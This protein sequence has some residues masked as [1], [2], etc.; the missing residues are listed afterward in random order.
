MSRRMQFRGWIGALL[1]ALA[2]AGGAC[3]AERTWVGAA[4]GDWFQAANWDGGVRPADGDSVA[5]SNG[6]WI[7]I[8]NDTPLLD[9]FAITNATLVFTNWDTT[10][11]A[12]SVLV[13]NSG[14]LTMP[15][16]FA[17]ASNRIH[18]ACSNLTVEP[19]G[20]I[21]ARGLGY[22]A[23]FGPGAGAADRG[24]G[25]G[26][27]GR[28][29]VGDTDATGGGTYDSAG[30]PVA[31][32][33]GGCSSSKGGSGGG[34]VRIDASGTI[35]I[36]GTITAD[37][38]SSTVNYGGGGSGGSVLII[39]D[40]FA[41]GTGGLVSASGGAGTSPG[42]GGGGGRLAIL[43]SHATPWPGV[44]LWTSPGSGYNAAF[45]FRAEA[46]TLHLADL[47]A[48]APVMDANRFR[49][50]NLTIEGVATCV[51][52]SL[53][54][55]NCSFRLAQPG[56][57]LI[58][59]NALVVATNAR[60]GTDNLFCDR[61]TITNGGV[62]EIVSA[63]TNGVEPD[64]GALIAVT[65]GVLI[66]PAS[67]LYLFAD[68]MTGGAP[69]LRADSV[70]VASGGAI[71][72]D[73]GGFETARGPGAG[74]TGERCAGGGYGGAGGRGQYAASG[75]SSYGAVSEPLSAGSG[76]CLTGGGGYGGGLIRIEAA[77]SVNVFGTI[78]ANGGSF[79][80]G[81]GGG[82]SGGGVFIRCAALGGGTSGLI[83]ANGGSGSGN[84]AGGGGG[85]RIALHYANA[86]PWPGI[87]MGTSPGS[88]YAAPARY[89]ATDGSVYLPD[90]APLGETL[91]GGL[92]TDVNLWV[93]GMTAWSV[94]RLTVSNCSVRLAPPGF[95][96]TVSNDVVL[97]AGAE[98][99]TVN[100]ACG[101]SIRLTNG[102]VLAV[103][104]DATGGAGRA[105]GALVQATNELAIGTSSWVTLHAH[106]TDGGAPLLRAAAIRVAAG[107]GVSADEG[108][109]R[110]AYGPG[111]GGTASRGR[112]AGYGGRGGDS[113][114]VHVGGN[115][116][117]SSNA[118][119]DPGSGG[120]YLNNGGYGGGLVRLETPGPLALDG[121][122]R[123]NGGNGFTS[124]GGGGSGGGI[125]ILCDSLS[126]G[127]S[128][129][130]QA[131][132]GNG[133][134]QAGGGGGGRISVAIGLSGADR[135]LL[136]SWAAVPGQVVYP[137]HAGFA[138]TLSATYGTGYS[139]GLP[140]TAH[141]LTAGA[142]YALTVAGE[143]GLFDSPGPAGYG[144]VI[145]I[146]SG[147]WITNGVTS[148]ADETNGLRR[149]CIGWRL[150]AIDGTPVVAGDGAQAEFEM[151]TNLVLTWRW[152]NEWQLLVSAGP[153]GSVND[154]A[155][156]GWYTNGWEVPGIAASASVG[157]VFTM[158][159]GAGVPPGH[160][161]D[162]PLTVTM[163]RARTFQASF[164]TPAGESKS[165]SGVGAWESATNWSPSG[166]P[167]PNDSVTIATGT[168][169][170]S[171][172]RGAFDLVVSN[173]ATLVFTN[174]DTRLAVSN[175]A[176]VRGGGQIRLA[177][178]F[179]AGGTSNRISLWCAS[180]LVQTG[181]VIQADGSGYAGRNGPGRGA[182]GTRG[183][184]GGHG[185]RGGYGSTPDAAGGVTNGYATA[186][187]GPGSGGG[188]AGGG[189]G[190]GVVRIE[191][192]GA[193]TV[194]GTISANGASGGASGNAGGG[195]GGSIFVSCSTFGGSTAG[196]VRASGGAGYSTHGGAGGGGRIAIHGA[197]ADTPRVRL[198]TAAGVGY[199]ENTGVEAVGWALAAV[200][201]TVY[202]TDAALLSETLS[203]GLFG[204]VNLYVSGVTSWAVGRLS[205]SN[206]SVTFAEGGFALTV[207]NALT[208]GP[209][210]RLGV[211]S[212]SCGDVVLTD[213]GALAVFAA[214]TNGGLREYGALVEVT[215]A[216]AVSSGSWLY[217]H[218]DSASGG[219][220]EM[221][222]GRVRIDAG[223]GISA[224]GRGFATL[225]GP[226]RGQ[227]GTGSR[228]GGGGYGGRGGSGSTSGS[229]GG[230]TYGS[231]N[232]PATAGSGG[233]STGG[234]AL[235]GY[236]G[237]VIWL[238]AD[239]VDM[240]GTLT[241]S[242]ANGMGLGGGGSGGAIFL[243]TRDFAGAPGSSL[244]AAGGSG[245]DPAH[246]GG[247]GGGRMAVWC[248]F[249]P[250][251]RDIL[252]GNPDAPAVTLDGTTVTNTCAGFAGT[253]SATPG[254]GYE[255]GQTGTVVFVTAP[256]RRGALL[257]VR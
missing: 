186:P 24:R 230:G 188:Q 96:L 131:K 180:L 194:Y 232:A 104:A 222:A 138:G 207:T 25:G 45:P 113:D 13:R 235:G 216:V 137:A 135:D 108:G 136:A 238:Y 224:R 255:S 83:R 116:Y 225:R 172:S 107:G 64:Y 129:L 201:G 237:G 187:E 22:L 179:A 177:G 48:I 253:A 82:G 123:A 189:A 88:G 112:G 57:T 197:L 199:A 176:T 156:S 43:Y 212:L 163:D 215:R 244:T 164:T 174:W 139:N 218:A 79:G 202:L 50:V 223:G 169:W 100:L 151:T 161:T 102:G 211:R 7:V 229:A 227:T 175:G 10:L 72:A 157:Y 19:G 170:L 110:A 117:G 178:P 36:R 80:F 243:V 51:I 94:G 34:A 84:T 171:S 128:G 158:W 60:V 28:G 185:G 92:F 159:V 11:N 105:Y 242:G 86:T 67:T 245:G 203:G 141:F 240:R 62:L 239:S 181:G 206:C 38:S 15:A 248:G 146:P 14:R 20:R 143:P 75:G 132:G 66:G 118:P 119:V 77:G 93:S 149:A 144:T 71:T 192:A 16:P 73:A 44:R 182:D 120:C 46:G 68:K 17:S 30:A 40:T 31:P 204:D 200:G 257:L 241:A 234:T 114:T 147:T 140:G 184:G 76:G 23:T 249:M 154:G 35:D 195:A 150:A 213:G 81:Y 95:E 21:D 42:G 103:Y 196:V 173:G 33:S 233:G 56:F 130:V 122:I 109:Y 166:M 183:G 220:V 85:G 226:G 70:H 74:D 198:Q 2:A 3:A 1:A 121:T 214:A 221:R 90:A 125:L 26:H 148:P 155:V 142:G 27:G 5:L 256:A 55:S 252:L 89:R 162:N 37:G 127:A 193:V 165:W 65:N 115:T 205:V 63:A 191:A 59:S 111:N 209:G 32:G 18:V 126:G 106:D 52:D 145:S 160:E 58:V 208:I 219:P 39:C 87:R 124:I 231:T 134:S 228:G 98:L 133:V 217:V 210:G 29:G 61:V 78:S 41:G 250:A 91:S 246:G 236:G 6:V 168:V 4:T 99:G 9:V 8:S 190:G 254:T 49:D 12:V 152:T 47:S 54:V 251:Q 53:T 167:G 153:N 69:L 97:G 247:G 101:G